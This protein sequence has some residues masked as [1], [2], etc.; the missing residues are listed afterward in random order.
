MHI[1]TV[2]PMYRKEKDC[3]NINNRSMSHLSEHDKL[4]LSWMEKRLIMNVTVSNK[5]NKVTTYIHI[6]TI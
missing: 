6:H 3:V 2:Y 1:C 4:M 5:D